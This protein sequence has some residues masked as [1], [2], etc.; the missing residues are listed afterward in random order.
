MIIKNFNFFDCVI[1]NFKQENCVLINSQF[2][3]E[4]IKE[5]IG[6]GFFK[7]GKRMANVLRM[8]VL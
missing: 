4:E 1:K 7:P 3:L 8:F 6:M 2:R 5:R